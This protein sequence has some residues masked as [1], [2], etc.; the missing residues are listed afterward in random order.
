MQ[1]RE[2]DSKGSQNR[3]HTDDN[4]KAKRSST[5]EARDD[6]R[7]AS[8]NQTD[9]SLKVARVAA[10]AA[11]AASREKADAARVLGTQTAEEIVRF[12]RRRGDAVIADERRMADAAFSKEREER[13]KV[14]EDFLR[15]ERTTT[16]SD[17]AQERRRTGLEL[18]SSAVMLQS[19]RTA[20]LATRVALATRDELMAIVSHDLRNPLSAISMCAAMLIEESTIQKLDAEARTWI[21]FIKRNADTGMRLVEDLLDMERVANDKLE[22]QRN[23]CDLGE[24]VG[25]AVQNFSATAA[26]KSILLR[27]APTK[28]SIEITCDRDRVLQAVSNLIGNAVKFTQ[29]GGLVNVR[30]ETDSAGHAQILVSDNGPGIPA[31]RLDQVFERFSQLGT[32]DRIGLGLGLYISKMIAEAHHGSLRVASTVGKGS[33]FTLSLPSSPDH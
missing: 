32:K 8:A 19:E 11:S 14:E 33:T 1:D 5:D 26:A 22:L 27:I 12:E 24:M 31:D 3:D 17:L 30:V 13:K 29:D 6:L 9:I 7:I 4:L 10:D 16:D 2:D 20:H 18:S 28:P 25:E 15:S 23:A 21:A